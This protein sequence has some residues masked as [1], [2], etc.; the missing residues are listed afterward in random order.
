MVRKKQ[1]KAQLTYL[2]TKG[3]TRGGGRL[4]LERTKEFFDEINQKLVEWRESILESDWILFQCTPRLW[5]GLF[6]ATSNPIFFKDDHRIRKIAI[7]TYE[8]SLKELK[9]INH[10]LFNGTVTLTSIHTIKSARE[11]ISLLNES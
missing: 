5:N 9:R 10:L 3:K 11:L 2:L 6:D 4:R 8:P 7:N 1:G